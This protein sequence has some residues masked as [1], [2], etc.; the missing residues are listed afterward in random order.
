M[1]S[2][3]AAQLRDALRWALESDA[4]PATAAA[5][6]L[7]RDID[8]SRSSA[9]DLLTDSAV[10]LHHLT[11]AK[12]V[13]KTMRVLGETA[14]DRCLGARLYLAA[15]AAALVVYRA[16]IS[17]QSDRAI[18]RA[19]REMEKDIDISRPLRDLATRALSVLPTLEPR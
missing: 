10:P 5:D 16:R 14:A 19:L 8:P 12:H 9:L 4:D 7:A 6:W 13:Y 15:I 11:D 17:R 3:Q 18:T 2:A 1:V